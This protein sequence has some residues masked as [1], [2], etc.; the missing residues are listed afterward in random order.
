MKQVK[1]AYLIAVGFVILGV[2]VL[3]GITFAQ[4]DKQQNILAEQA[5]K[6]QQAEQSRQAEQVRQAEQAKEAAAAEERRVA[7]IRQQHE[8]AERQRQQEKIR[9][10]LPPKMVMTEERAMQVTMAVAQAFGQEDG[11]LL[12]VCIKSGFD[13]DNPAQT[14]DPNS[15][16]PP[17][18][19]V[20]VIGPG[21][22]HNGPTG[23]RYYASEC[24]R[25]R[26][27]A[28]AVAAQYQHRVYEPAHE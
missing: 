22:V 19:Q 12:E 2:S 16:L 6:A 10:G 20:Q 26:K 4:Y 7:E 5:Q 1:P 13:W 28:L 27:K 21:G 18:Y 24:Y 17:I 23:P 25:L 8:E 11:M 9:K 3:G 14:I 15:P